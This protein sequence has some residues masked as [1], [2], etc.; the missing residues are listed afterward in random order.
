M[1]RL[2]RCHFL[3]LT[4]T[5]IVA[6]CDRTLINQ[7]NTERHPQSSSMSHPKLY[8]NLLQ[9]VSDFR[10]SSHSGQLIM[11]NALLESV[12]SYAVGELFN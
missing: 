1:V 12:F 4:Q 8:A 2:F 10:V 3:P 6:D 11:P 9:L 7:D 5:P